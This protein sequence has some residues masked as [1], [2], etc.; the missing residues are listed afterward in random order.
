MVA[1]VSGLT[2]PASGTT[3]PSASAQAQMTS[4]Q[5][6]QILT[7]EL[8]SQDPLNPMSNSDFVQQLVGLQSLQ[9]TASLTDSLQSFQTF[10]QMSAGGALIGKT[11]TGL[12]ADGTQVQGVVSSVSFQNGAANLVVGSQQIPV[13][14][15]TAIDG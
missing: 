9:Q 12:A 15:V 3:S 8:T 7:A 6:M 1:P 14:S 4:A 2:T 11:V 5:F 10:M 13:S